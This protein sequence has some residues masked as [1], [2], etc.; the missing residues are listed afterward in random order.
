MQCVLLP[1][2][3]EARRLERVQQAMCG[4]PAEP[5]NPVCA[6]EAL[7]EG[8]R[9]GALPLP[10]E[11]THSGPGLQ[12][13]RLPPRVEPRAL[14]SVFQ[15]LWARGEE[16]GSAVQKCLQ[17]RGP[18]REPVRRRPQT[19]VAGGLCPGAMSQKHPATVGRLLVE[20]VLGDL[21]AGGEEEGNE[22]QREGLPG[23]ADNFPRAKVPQH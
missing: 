3:L 20:R 19:R 11:H 13:P 9:G 21:W 17:G 8:G 22:V 4:G 2:L 7:P 6:E 12:Q 14:V 5:E 15:D 18:P 16:A 10:S 1:C 23:E